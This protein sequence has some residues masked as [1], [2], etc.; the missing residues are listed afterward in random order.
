[1]TT[2]TTHMLRVMGHST[3]G[4]KADDTLIEDAPVV[5][6]LAEHQLQLIPSNSLANVLKNCLTPGNGPDS[7]PLK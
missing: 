7:T 1:M 4:L 6:N 5:K 3:N 2:S